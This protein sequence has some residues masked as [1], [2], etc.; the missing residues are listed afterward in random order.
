MSRDESTK[1]ASD[2][3]RYKSKESGSPFGGSG[4]MGTMSCYKCGLHKLRSLA[5]IGLIPKA[6]WTKYVL[7]QR[8]QSPQ[9]T[10]TSKFLA[11]RFFTVLMLIVLCMSSAF[12]QRMYG[13]SGRQIGRA[14]GLRR[15]QLI[16]YFYFFK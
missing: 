16:I 13:S 11:P 2:G 6:S 15:M 7:L 12:S 9:M 1:I 4:S 10:Y 5:F 14:E 3:L 8:L